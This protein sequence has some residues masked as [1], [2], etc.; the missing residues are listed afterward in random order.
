VK[1]LDNVLSQKKATEQLQNWTKLAIILN[2]SK[3]YWHNFRF[4]SFSNQQ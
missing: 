3:D 4:S 2:A 1:K